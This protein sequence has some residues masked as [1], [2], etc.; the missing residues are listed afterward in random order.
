MFLTAKVTSCLILLVLKSELSQ[1]IFK[2]STDI[3]PTTI[4]YVKRHL[5]LK[6]MGLNNSNLLVDKKKLM[7][8]FQKIYAICF[9]EKYSLDRRGRH[10]KGL[11]NSVKEELTKL[12]VMNGHLRCPLVCVFQ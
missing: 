3:R 8:E 7:S 6:L 1:A 2:P 9:G 10:F 12:V 4:D 5:A 11:C